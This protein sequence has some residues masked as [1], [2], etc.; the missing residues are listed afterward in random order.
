MLRGRRQL[1]TARRGDPVATAE[2]QRAIVHSALDLLEETGFEELSLRRL[3]R[4]LGMHAPGLYWYI[5]SKQELVDL[6]AKAILE[7]GLGP[8]RPL[9]PGQTW[10]QWLIELA[11]QT[12]EAL[13]A[14][15]DGAR[16]VAGAYLVRTNTI[17]PIIEQALTILEDAG[18]DRLLAL[19]GTMTLLRYAIGIALD[20]QASPV[21]GISREGKQ[22]IA[23]AVHVRNGRTDQMPIPQI[24]PTRWPRTADALQQVVERNLRDPGRMFRAGAAMIV[25][26]LAQS[27]GLA[28]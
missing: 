7:E 17:T 12:R 19:A 26:G 4:H 5:E 21:R 10:E 14:H 24:D 20:E 27:R 25:R 22:A 11:C 3:A 23:V 16:I 15:R 2:R 18:F 13:L 28:K 9:E 8:V 1:S 6:M